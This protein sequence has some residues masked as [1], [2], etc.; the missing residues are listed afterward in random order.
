MPRQIID[1]FQQAM[2]GKTRRIGQIAGRIG[3][4]FCQL[5]KVLRPDRGDVAEFIEV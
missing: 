5:W 2:A 1:L 4:D 3:Y